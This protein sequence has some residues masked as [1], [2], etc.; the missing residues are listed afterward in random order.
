MLPAA[1]PAAFPEALPLRVIEPVAEPRLIVVGAELRD[2]IAG[3]GNCRMTRSA[4][5]TACPDTTTECRSTTDPSGAAKPCSRI[6]PVAAPFDGDGVP[7]PLR[8]IDPDAE[9]APGA[10]TRARMMM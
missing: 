5:S 8:T 7:V 2:Q 4:D 6:D 1:A 9:I 10:E 3:S